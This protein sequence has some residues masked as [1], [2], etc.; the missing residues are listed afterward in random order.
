MTTRFSF[1]HLSG[2]AAALLHR[3]SE[4][5]DAQARVAAPPA[6]RSPEYSI[7]EP[8]PLQASVAQ[9]YHY[10]RAGFSPLGLP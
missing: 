8:Q 9:V 2:M 5:G 3:S 6:A 1:P 4:A 10:R 7:A